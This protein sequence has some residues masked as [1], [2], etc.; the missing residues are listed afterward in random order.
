[1]LSAVQFA[2]LFVFR[3]VVAGLMLGFL[4]GVTNASPEFGR[5]SACVGSMPVHVM[6]G[7]PSIGAV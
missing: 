5:N 2:R 6:P 4:A 3:V 7:D 1:M